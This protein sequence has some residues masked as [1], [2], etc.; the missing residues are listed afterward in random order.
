[1]VGAQIL[2]VE[3]DVIIVME[4]RDKLQSLGYAV[5]GVASYGEEAIAKAGETRPDLVL[6][7]IKL[8]GEMDGVEAAEEIRERFDIPVICLTA[9]A[10]ENTLQ[11]AKVTEPYGYII[12]PFEKRELYSTI[13]TALYK[14]EMERKLKE[15]ERWLD[16]TLRSI[17]DAVI[18]TDKKGLIVFMNPVAETLTGWKQEDALGKDLTEVFHIIEEETRILPESPV[19]KALR[20]GVIVGLANH[21]LLIATCPALVDAIEAHQQPGDLFHPFTADGRRRKILVP[22]FIIRRLRDPFPRK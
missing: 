16:T 15:S 6:M 5:A 17:G 3:D 19:T 8:K 21:S 10:D 13:E 7:D 12:K 1:M 14:H 9:Y 18:A 20:E 11:R 2:V 4:L 22:V